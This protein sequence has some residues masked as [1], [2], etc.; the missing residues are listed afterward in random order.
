MAEKAL[1]VIVGGTGKTGRRV[2]QRLAERG[3]PIRL[4]TR[5]THPTFDWERPATWTPALE[6]A[7]SAYVT[8][9]PDLAVPGAAAAVGE[10][11]ELAVRLGVRRLVLLSGRGEEGAQRGERAVQ[12]SG[13]EWTIL[14]CSWFNQNF[15]EGAFLDAVRSG[16]VALPAGDTREPFVD[17]DDIA[18]AAAAALTEECHAGHVYELTGPRLLSFGEA[19]GEIGRA[20]G[21][22]IRY[23]PLS[24]EEYAAAMAGLGGPSTTVSLIRYLFEE[25]L[26]GRNARLADGFQLAVG[27]PAR[28]FRD[29]ARATASTGVWNP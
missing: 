25:V 14:R 12:E 28:D 16:E 26:D 11:A 29:Y 6:G 13:A 23:A 18:E 9:S 4:A 15:S 21:R 2:A 17:A 24:V 1:T 7:R 5:S 8:Y 19:V 10:L 27:R 3:V 20:T 22:R